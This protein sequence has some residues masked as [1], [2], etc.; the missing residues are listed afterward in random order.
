MSLF[1]I[2]ISIVEFGF[3]IIYQVLSYALSIIAAFVMLVNAIIGNIL[4][5]VFLVLLAV[6]Y[7]AVVYA[8]ILPFQYIFWKKLEEIS[9]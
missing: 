7:D 3:G 1:C 9:G 5:Y 2:C 6:V 4:V 8:V